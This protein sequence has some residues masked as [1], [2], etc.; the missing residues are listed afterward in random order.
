MNP[1]NRW[2]PVAVTG[3]VVS[4]QTTP[5][6]PSD[7]RVAKT[8]RWPVAWSIHSP[9]CDEEAKLVPLPSTIVSG[10]G[11]QG[12]ASVWRW[13]ATWRVFWWWKTL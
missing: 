8:K 11:Q 3:S 1:Q 10:D 9:G 4:M 5:P 6:V 13:H 12:V 7:T 2:A